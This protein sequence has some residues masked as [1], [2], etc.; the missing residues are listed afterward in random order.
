MSLTSKTQLVTKMLCALIHVL[1]QNA[2]DTIM[3]K[4]KGG[5]QALKKRNIHNIHNKL[6]QQFYFTFQ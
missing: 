2:L 3:A 6:S 1:T 5:V 4:E